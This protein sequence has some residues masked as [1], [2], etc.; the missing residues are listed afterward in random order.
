MLVIFDKNC[1]QCSLCCRIVTHLDPLL[2]NDWTVPSL[3]KMSF[4]NAAWKLILT[5]QWHNFCKNESKTINLMFMSKKM[6]ETHINPHPHM[7][8]RADPRK[9]CQVRIWL[10]ESQK[11]QST[12]TY[13]NDPLVCISI[14]LHRLQTSKFFC[15]CRWG[16]TCN[17]LQSWGLN[18]FQ[19]DIAFTQQKEKL[20]TIVSYYCSIWNSF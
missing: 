20:T 14:W 19:C 16:L 8:V 17:F 5:S 13:Y 2:Y 11:E 12:L 6:I 9:L 4:S 10:S 3:W 7:R 18:S 1:L 15:T